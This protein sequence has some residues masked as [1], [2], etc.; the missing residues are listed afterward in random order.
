MELGADEGDQAIVAAIITLAH[1]L[2]LRVIA[3]GVETAS[4]ALQL[5]ALGC[6]QSQGH[7]FSPPQP[8][9]ELTALLA[10]GTVLGSLPVALV[11]RR[12]PNTSELHERR[13][14][15][16]HRLLPARGALDPK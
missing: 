3:E 11:P 9:R 6:D 4:Q 13:T 7:H 10:R 16:S 1:T 12:T 5:R 8:A 15:R 2:G 14:Q